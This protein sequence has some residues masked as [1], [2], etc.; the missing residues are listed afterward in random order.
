MYLPIS[1]AAV[2][3]VSGVFCLSINSVSA[4]TFCFWLLRSSIHF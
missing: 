3:F 4:A 1:A 2:F